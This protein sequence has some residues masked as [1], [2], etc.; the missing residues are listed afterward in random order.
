MLSPLGTQL[1]NDPSRFQVHSTSLCSRS[2][3]LPVLHHPSHHTPTHRL[4][5]LLDGIFCSLFH[6]N[7][8]SSTANAPCSDSMVRHFRDA[9]CHGLP[10]VPWWSGEGV[11]CFRIRILLRTFCVGCISQDH[12]A[13]PG[14]DWKRGVVSAVGRLRDHF[15][16]QQIVLGVF[17]LT[18]IGSVYKGLLLFHSHYILYQLNLTLFL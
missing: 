4:V 17:I 5:P 12:V 15:W 13:S 3:R 16:V 9:A 10:L 8:H 7:Q 2:L 1:N 6:S 14:S 18:Y 11:V